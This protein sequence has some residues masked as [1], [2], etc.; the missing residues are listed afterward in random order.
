MDDDAT[1][2]PFVVREAQRY[3]HHLT[4]GVRLSEASPQQVAEAI[5]KG[6]A[7]E[8]AH[9]EW[10][11]ADGYTEWYNDEPTVELP[12]VTDDGPP[13][14]EMPAISDEDAADGS[15]P[16]LYDRIYFGDPAEV[17]GAR[18]SLRRWL[19]SRSCP[20][21]EDVVL[22]ASELAANAILHSASADLYWSLRAEIH[23]DHV[24]VEVEDLGGPWPACRAADGHHGLDIVAALSDGRWGTTVRGCD[25]MRVTWAKVTIPQGS[26]SPVLRHLTET[27]GPAEKCTQ[28]AHSTPTD[29]A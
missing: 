25:G 29:A 8:K 27:F 21:A 4:A 23:D 7:E 26:S 10:Y 5:H 9:P 18:V 20:V 17:H 3:S 1:R 6:L 24:A 19:D 11:N 16:L 2:F 12:P 15:T 28:L 13:T 14:V 22:I